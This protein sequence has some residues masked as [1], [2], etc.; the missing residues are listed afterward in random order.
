M[1]APVKQVGLVLR[2]GGAIAGCILGEILNNNDTPDRQ[3]QQM[4]RKG[5]KWAEEKRPAVAL[6]SARRPPRPPPPPSTRLTFISLAMRL[7]AAMTAPRARRRMHKQ[8][9]A[10]MCEPCE[11]KAK[12]ERRATSESTRADPSPPPPPPARRPS[13]CRSPVCECG[14]KGSVCVTI[15]RVCVA[16]GWRVDQRRRAQRWLAV[17]RCTDKAKGKK[18]QTAAATDRC[19]TQLHVKQGLIDPTV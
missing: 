7:A 1:I 5:K 16:V 11:A 13:R 18:K 4:N 14:G 15:G 3:Q 12:W 9:A 17:Q 2:A 19:T 6:P 10:T 8:T